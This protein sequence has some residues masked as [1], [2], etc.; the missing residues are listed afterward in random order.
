MVYAVVIADFQP[1]RADELECKAGEAVVIIAISTPEW[2]VG[3]PIGRL[4]GP[5][6]VPLSFLEL[7]DMET[8]LPIANTSDALKDAQVPSVQEWKRAAEVHKDGMIRLLP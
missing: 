6:L 2:I 1:E 8:N 5:G 7:R 4:G 3:K